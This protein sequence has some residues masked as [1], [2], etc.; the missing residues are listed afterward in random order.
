MN[1]ACL[2][3]MKKCPVYL[4]FDV[5]GFHDDDWLALVMFIDVVSG[6]RLVRTNWRTGS[7][8]GGNCTFFSRLT[9]LMFGAAR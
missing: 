5:R 6:F 2:P 4:E 7:A 8:I 9:M 1:G 3:L